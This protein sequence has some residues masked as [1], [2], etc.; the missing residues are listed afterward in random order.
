MKMQKNV[1]RAAACAAVSAVMAA[2]IL[3]QVG[4][5]MGCDA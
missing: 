2:M 4:E 3:I 5:R 1:L